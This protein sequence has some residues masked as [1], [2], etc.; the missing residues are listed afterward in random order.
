RERGPGWLGAFLTEA[1]ERGPAP[2]L[3]EAAEEFARLT[4]VSSTLARLL[5][6][7]LPHID[8]YEHHFLPAELRTALGVKAAEAKHARSELTSLQIEVR[9][10][11]VAALLPAD[12][13][14]LWSEGPDV[15]AA[16]QV[17]NARVG[18]RTPVPEWL[19]AEATRAAKTGWSTHRALAALLD[20]AQSRT[21]GVDVA[22][23]VKGDHVEPAE[24]ATEPFTSTVLTGAVTLTAWLAHRL[25]AGDPLRAALPPALTAVRQRL[26][27]PE[28]MLSIGHFTHLPEFRKAAGTPTETG[29]GYERYGAVVMA[30]YDDRP[31][32]AVR[33]ALLDSTGCDPYLPALRGEDQQPSPEETALRAVHDPRLAALLADPGAPAAGAVDKDGTWWPQDPSRSV[34]ELVA[35]VSE[36]HGLGADAA[37]VYLALLAMPDPTDRNVARWTGWKPARLKAARAELGAT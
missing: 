7:G 32:P 12:P 2:F 22:W 20:P 16:A 5:L 23:E 13:A 19:L 11:V 10:E 25:P 29:E 4:G 6:A 36:A 31:R 17:W 26:A 21:L 3:P 28:L 30:T 37:A 8:S 9:R 15:A 1:A 14:R 18:R 24:P 27:A 33:T 34:P 35:E